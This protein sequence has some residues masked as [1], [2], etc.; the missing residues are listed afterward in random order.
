MR[1]YSKV[2]PQIWAGQTGKL[3]GQVTRFGAESDLAWRLAALAAKIEA[4]F[5]LTKGREV[6]GTKVNETAEGRA[7]IAAATMALMVWALE[8]GEPWGTTE[9]RTT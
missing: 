7:Q 6:L 3:R 2:S 9:R 5:V 4:Y 8:H 1:D